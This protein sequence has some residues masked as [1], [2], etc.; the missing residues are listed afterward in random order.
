MKNLLK[1]AAPLHPVVDCIGEFPLSPSMLD[2]GVPKMRDILA[3]YISRVEATDAFEN[4]LIGRLTGWSKRSRSRAK[5]FLF[6]AKEDDQTRQVQKIVQRRLA[7]AR[8]YV[9]TR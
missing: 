7:E 8:G 4:S 2:H 1:N 9:S 5:T 3:E 6:L